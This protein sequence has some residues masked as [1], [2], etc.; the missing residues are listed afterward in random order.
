MRAHCARRTRSRTD[1]VDTRHRRRDISPSYEKIDANRRRE[2]LHFYNLST[3]KRMRKRM[4]FHPEK[5][6]ERSYKYSARGHLRRSS[7]ERKFVLRK[8]KVTSHLLFSICIT[9]PMQRRYSGAT[10]TRPRGPIDSEGPCEPVE[11]PREI[12]AGTP[13]THA[14]PRSC[15]RA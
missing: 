4:Y 14:K 13:G 11:E 7:A 15:A 2:L 10:L 3:R 9:V 6:H 8:R 5:R 12:R 1:L